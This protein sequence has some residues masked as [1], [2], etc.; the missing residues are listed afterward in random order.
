MREWRCGPIA[1]PTA[2]TGWLIAFAF[3]LSCSSAG[4]RSPADASVESPASGG[5]SG[6]SDSSTT[7]SSGIAVVGRQVLVDGLPFHVKGVC[8]N[9]VRKGGTHPGDL[10]FAGA[11]PRDIPLMKAAGINAVRTYEPL[12][13]R[14]VLD[15]LWAAGIR[16]LNTV[17]SYGGNA[18]ATAADP[19]RAV[20]D[21]PAILLW[22]VGNE[23]NYNG[24]YVGMSASDAQ[25]RVAQAVAVV[26]ANDTTHPIATVYGD[27]PSATTI[28]ALP[29]VDLWGVNVYRGL[30]FGTLFDDWRARSAKPF[31]ISEYGADAWNAKLPGVDTASQAM[32]TRSLTQ[33]IRDHGSAYSTSGSCIGGALFEWAD[34]WWKDAN[35]SPSVHDVGGVAPG[36]GPYPDMTFNEEW[37]GIVDIDRVPRSAYQELMKLFAP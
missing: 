5:Q 9:P 15:A 24:L 19:V 10:D 27:L 3:G 34:E 30:D 20:K 23:W 32:A 22:I 17:Y 26:R 16:V 28:A 31:L 25:A 11:A 37:W 33:Q 8:W 29:E 12:T 18:V 2:V 14:S 13:D 35:G 36:G 7:S 6:A 4:S 21:H 1:T